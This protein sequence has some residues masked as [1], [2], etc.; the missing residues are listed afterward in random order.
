ML[1]VCDGNITNLSFRCMQKC[2]HLFM[3]SFTDSVFLTL[4]YYGVK[5][6]K[7]KKRQ[8]TQW[9]TEKKGASK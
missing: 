3:Q 2:I 1:R 5:S 6:K 4:Y 7:D 9:T 8:N